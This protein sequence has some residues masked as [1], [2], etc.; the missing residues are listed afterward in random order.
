MSVFPDNEDV[1][2]LVLDG[3]E[4]YTRRILVSVENESFRLDL[5]VAEQSR[6]CDVQRVVS[7][8]CVRFGWGDDGNRVVGSE[9]ALEVI[10]GGSWSYGRNQSRRERA[11]TVKRAVV[12]SVEPFLDAFGV[13]FEPL[14]TG[15]R[16][17][18]VPEIGKRVGIELLDGRRPNEVID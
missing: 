11:C 5:G 17:D 15:E 3:S 13:G 1:R 4:N 16:R 9:T 2:F 8:A 7:V 14:G 6:V 10:A 12:L 18:R